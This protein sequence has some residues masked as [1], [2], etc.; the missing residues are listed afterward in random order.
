HAD[1]LLRR[2]QLELALLLQAPQLVQALDALRDGPPV[3]QQPAEPA[4]AYVRHADTRRLLLDGVLR[5]LLRADE[6][7]RAATPGEV[8]REFVRLLEQL[9]GLLQVDDVDA[10]ALGED[11]ALHLRIPAAGL[12]AEMDPGLQELA[13]AYDSHG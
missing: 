3:R 1:P 13:H 7:H 10:A 2:E 9:E 6:Q 12:V 4:M 11:E 8:P 5:L